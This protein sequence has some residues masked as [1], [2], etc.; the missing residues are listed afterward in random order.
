MPPTGSLSETAGTIAAR[1]AEQTVLVAERPGGP[2]G[3]IFAKPED[4]DFH[5]GR[6]AVLP[7]A[8]GQGIAIELLVAAEAEARRLGCPGMTLNVR[9]ALHRQRALYERFGFRP[10]EERCHPGFTEPTFLRMRKPL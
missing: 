5:V 6:L 3:C 10:V 2:V 7:A 8:R 4:G 9:L 1:F